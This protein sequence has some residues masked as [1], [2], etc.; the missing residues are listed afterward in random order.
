MRLE[1]RPPAISGESASD[2]KNCGFGERRIENLF[3]KFGGKFLGEPK[4][5][6]FRIFNVFAENDTPRIFLESE[7][8]SLVYSIANPIFARWQN[9]LVDLR[10]RATDVCLELVRRRVLRFF[11]FGLFATDALFDFVVILHELFVRAR[12]FGDQF[13]LP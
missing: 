1:D 7:T 9:L 2:T 3:R 11:R 5:A 6:A 13:F 10:E 12:A 4:D 8:Q